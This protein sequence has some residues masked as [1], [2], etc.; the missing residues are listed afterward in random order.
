MLS[1][2]FSLMRGG[3]VQRQ[4]HCRVG[5]EASFPLFQIRSGCGSPFWSSS[6]PRCPSSLIFVRD[7]GFLNGQ[8]VTVMSQ[9]VG[10]GERGGG[11][12]GVWGVSLSAL[13]LSLHPGLQTISHFCFLVVTSFP[14]PQAQSCVVSK[15]KNKDQC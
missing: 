15:V 6:L 2:S 3:K 11:G 13:P 5:K 8:C 4:V 14:F 1:K 12:R 9:Q 10:A 7:P